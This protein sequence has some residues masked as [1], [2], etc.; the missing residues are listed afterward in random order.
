MSGTVCLLVLPFVCPSAFAAVTLPV[1]CACWKRGPTPGLTALSFPG[2]VP[3]K[4]RRWESA[5][6][7]WTWGACP[8]EARGLLSLQATRGGIGALTLVSSLI[9][10]AFHMT[11]RREGIQLS[12]RKREVG[13]WRF[14]RAQHFLQSP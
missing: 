12:M 14:C 8:G 3:W 7:A 13:T 5:G 1:A 6:V 10:D 11:A 9:K 2:K 4:E